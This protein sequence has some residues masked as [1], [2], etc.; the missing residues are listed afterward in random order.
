M[1]EMLLDDQGGSGVVVRSTYTNLENEVGKKSR[2]YRA[3]SRARARSLK[4]LF[5]R[6]RLWMKWGMDEKTNVA[7]REPNLISMT[8]EFF[9]CLMN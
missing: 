5:D 4:T 6:E 1:G 8:Q 7:G 9:G 2:L 3:V